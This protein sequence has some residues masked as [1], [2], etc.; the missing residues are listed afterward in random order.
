MNRY[1]R[2]SKLTISVSTVPIRTCFSPFLSLQLLLLAFAVQQFFRNSLANVFKHINAW[3][4]NVTLV[5][6]KI[7]TQ[8]PSIVTLELKSIYGILMPYA[9]LYDLLQVNLLQPCCL[10]LL[11]LLV[12]YPGSISPFPV[13]ECTCLVW[14]CGKALMKM[15]LY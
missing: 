13:S 2:L 8:N 12:T 6:L 14:D 4:V 15:G 10:E 5:K 1:G 7:H 9:A 11:W 3:K